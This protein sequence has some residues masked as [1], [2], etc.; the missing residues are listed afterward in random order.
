M[1]VRD[2]RWPQWTLARFTIRRT[3]RAATLW[4]A[5]MALYTYAS[6]VG[7][8]DL[9]PSRQGRRAFVDALGGNLGLKALMGQPYRLDTVGGFVTWRATAV[10]SLIGAV[11]G[12]LLATDATR[13]EEAAGRW[14]LFLAGRV[15]RRRAALNALLGLG[16]A[17]AVLWTFTFVAAVVAAERPGVGFSIGAALLFATAV[18]AGA[19][20]FITVGA[21]AAQLMPTR[22]RAAA[23]AAA[24]FGVSF[25]LRAVA[26]VAPTAHWLVYASPLGWIEQIRALSDPRPQWLLPI[27]GL[28]TILVLATLSLAGRRDLDASTLPD[29]DTAV[30][31]TRLLGS[32]R[33]LAVRLT[34]T[35]ALAWTLAAAVGSMIYATFARSAGS[36]F[37]SSPAAARLGHGLAHGA[38]QIT[39]VRTFAG[40]VFLLV[41]LML[42]GYV[43]SALAA[44]REEEADGHLDNLL[45]A[46][47][48]RADWLSTRTLLVL[49]VTVLAGAGTGI[50][51]WAG[52]GAGAGLTLGELLQAGLNATAPA[53]LL[54]GIGVF[55]LGVLPRWTAPVCYALLAW[56][57]LL[58]MLGSVLHLNGWVLDTSLLQHPTL[59]PIT[60]PNWA[61]AGVYAALAT[62]LAAAG[63]LAFQRRDLQP[64]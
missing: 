10:L 61:V 23:L 30:A 28:I 4:G 15:T 13:G 45:A 6:V 1:T 41:M 49:A 42:M 56:S 21:L 60:T 43:A 19:A 31:R 29:R 52:S 55:T 20:Q 39:G 36:A 34:R 44:I 53:V 64:H 51:F 5:A 50:G 47:V 54:L 46:T 25:L 40:I 16:A 3:V 9:S 38:N 35:T 57:F 33:L 12:L 37:A 2:L 7:F 8:Q 24:V 11:W 22:A 17:V 48:G 14:E 63:G 27:A 62:L 32:H 26:D 59:A 58:D 18:A